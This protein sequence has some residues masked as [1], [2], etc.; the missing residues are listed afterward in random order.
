MCREVKQEE[1]AN[2]RKA[3]SAPTR[4]LGTKTYPELT[5]AYL[6]NTVT[7]FPPTPHC[8]EGSSWCTTEVDYST[9]EAAKKATK[10]TLTICDA[11]NGDLAKELMI[12]REFSTLQ[13]FC[14]IT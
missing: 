10:F 1:D 6:C 4:E 5:S 12:E 7:G 11:P 3:S 2:C 13:W 14:A 8:A 9:V